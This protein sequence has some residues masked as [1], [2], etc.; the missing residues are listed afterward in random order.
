M[1]G[2][3]GVREVHL[4]AGALVLLRQLASGKRAEEPLFVTEGG[5]SWTPALHTRR[6]A[7]AVQQAGLDSATTFYALRHTYIS[8]ALRKGVPAKAVADHCGTSLRM[9]EANYA[10]FFPEDRARYAAIAAPE[11]RLGS[12]DSKV[13]QLRSGGAG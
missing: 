12:D 13:V 5:K 9:I 7:A 6:V 8:R 4:E 3:T 11:L 10:K 1:R 2:K